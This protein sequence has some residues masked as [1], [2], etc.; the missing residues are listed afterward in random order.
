MPLGDSPRLPG[1][2]AVYTYGKIEIYFQWLQGYPPFDQEKYRIDLL[3]KLN[4]LD[5]NKSAK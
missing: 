4:A 2:F 3:Q 5:W 1:I